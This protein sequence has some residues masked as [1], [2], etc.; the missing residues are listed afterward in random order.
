[1]HMGGGSDAQGCSRSTWGCSVVAA[2]LQR[3]CSVVAAWL[4][5]GCSVQLPTP[6]GG[7]Q[8][9]HGQSGARQT[10][11]CALCGPAPSAHGGGGARGSQ[12]TMLEQRAAGQG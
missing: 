10:T 9:R 12:C 6:H 5:R 1:M 11:L 2:W 7:G 8:R 3:V 4:Q